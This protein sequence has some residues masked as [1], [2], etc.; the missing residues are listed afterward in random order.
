MRRGGEKGL[1][2]TGF[3]GFSQAID[4]LDQEKN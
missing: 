2:K 1:G 4:L 3:G